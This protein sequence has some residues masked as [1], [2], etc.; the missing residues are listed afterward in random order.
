M[1]ADIL[2]TAFHA[3]AA[4][5]NR[6]NQWENRGGYTLAS[7]YSDASEEALAARFGA[8][9]ADLS[10]HWRVRVSGVRANAFVSRFFSRNAATLMP[11]TALEALW[12][13]DGGGLRGQGMVVRFGRDSF[14]II[15][16]VADADWLVPAARLYDLAVDDLNGTE[17]MLA[18]I[19]PASRRILKA[20]G[21]EEDV[22]PLGLRKLFWRG[23]DIALSRLGL[24]YEI[25][26]DPDSALIVWDRLMAAGRAYA[27]IP[28]GQAALDILELESGVLRPGRDYV[29]ARDGFAPAPAPQSLGL[30][31]RVDREHLFNGRAGFLA[32]RPDTFLRGILLDGETASPDAPVMLGGRPSGR[33]LRSFH[34]PSLRR[35]VALGVLTEAAAT[36][37]VMAGRLGGR[38]ADLPFLPI[39]A[40]IAATENAPS[41]V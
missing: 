3:R 24:G 7:S 28:A 34:S 21:V 33:V 5:A 14:V 27:L 22:E 6:L 2:A 9:L 18:L 36:G 38:L 4:E 16:A 1:T 17:G 31:D 29:P 41:G 13:N 20:A 25:W 12:L 26:C 35:A 19:G 8:V 15:S 11:G 30:A 23:H 39:P 32:A 40:P 37:E 10:W